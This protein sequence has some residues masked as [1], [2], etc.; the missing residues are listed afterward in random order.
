MPARLFHCALFEFFLMNFR[1]GDARIM[2]SGGE[3]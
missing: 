2:I 3:K 1:M